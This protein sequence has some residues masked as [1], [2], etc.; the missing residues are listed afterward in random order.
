[1][2]GHLHQLLDA[3]REF[4]Q[5]GANMVPEWT[6]DFLPVAQFPTNIHLDLM[7]HKKIPDHFIALNEYKVQ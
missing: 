3:G 7:T 2:A 4:G 1:M 6:D 5:A